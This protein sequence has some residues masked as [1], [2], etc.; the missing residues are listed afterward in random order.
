MHKNYVTIKNGS[1]Y[2]QLLKVEEGGD[3]SIYIWRRIGGRWYAH[4][5]YH[6]GFINNDGKNFGYRRHQKVGAKKLKQEIIA[7]SIVHS[8]SKLKGK[9]QILQVYHWSALHQDTETSFSKIN[10]SDLI[11]EIDEPI[12]RYEILLSINRD[13][14]MKKTEFFQTQK[15]DI[16]SDNFYI[17]LN[18]K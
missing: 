8:N 7:D 6:D 16:K 5:S 12:E 10:T 18:K 15:C 3:G 14:L 13:D 2:H 9:R 11:F 4:F 17:T 1:K